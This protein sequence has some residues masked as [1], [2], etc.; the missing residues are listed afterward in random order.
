MDNEM[1][2]EP[3]TATSQ[4]SAD[5]GCI[6]VSGPH[7]DYVLSDALGWREGPTFVLKAPSSR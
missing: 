2:L 3:P 5:A 7:R 4:E 1:T 6:F